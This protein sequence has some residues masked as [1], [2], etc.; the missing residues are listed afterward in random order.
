MASRPTRPRRRRGSRADAPP[1]ESDSR[2]RRPSARTL[3]RAGSRRAALVSVRDARPPASVDG[4]RAAGRT[5]RFRRHARVAVWRPRNTLAE[6]APVVVGTRDSSEADSS[7]A[8]HV[9]SFHFAR[10]RPLF[11]FTGVSRIRPTSRVDERSAHPRT[12]MRGNTPKTHL[13]TKRRGRASHRRQ[14][15]LRSQSDARR[16]TRAATFDLT[17]R[18]GSIVPRASRRLASRVASREVT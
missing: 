8:N 5:R 7:W 17:R 10:F 2:N 16:A 9:A 11:F 13:S 12:E 14:G 4:F 18:G 6:R 1:R 3:A 15:P